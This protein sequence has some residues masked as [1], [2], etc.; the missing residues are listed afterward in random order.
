LFLIIALIDD[1]ALDI[2][3]HNPFRK[4]SRKIG[5]NGKDKRDNKKANI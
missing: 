5:K 2:F 4:S 3:S 1:P